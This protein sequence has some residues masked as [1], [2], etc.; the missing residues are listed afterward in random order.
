M[1]ESYKFRLYPNE[2]QKVLLAKHFG[3]VRFV[4]NWALDYNTKQ[5]V[6]GKKYTGWMT[7]VSGGEFVKLKEDNPWLYEIGANSLINVVGHLDKAYQKFF[8]HQGGFPKYKSK[9]DNNQS[10]EVPSGLKLFFKE[11]KIQI[12]KFLNKKG[13]DNRIK[14]VFCRK[15]KKG[16]IG[17]AT[18]S[19]NAAGQYFVSFIV[20]TEESGRPLVNK[21][22]LTTENSLGV[23]FGLKHFITLSDGRVIDSPEFFKRTLDKVAWEQHKLSKKQ[24]GSKNREKQRL[25]VAKA[26]QHIS[27][28]REDF[29]H[30]LTTGL[31]N[32]SQIQAICIEDL[33]LRKMS[34]R[35]GRKVHDL[36]Y[37][38]FTTMLD[39]KLKRRGKHLL[40]IGRFEPSSQICSH[41]GHR[42][43]ISLNERTYRCPICGMEMDRDVNASR[44]IKMF[45]LRDIL[46]NNTD[47]T[48]G[49][50]ACGVEGSG[51]SCQTTQLKPSTLKQ[52]NLLD[53]TSNP[54]HL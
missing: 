6:Q 51:L 23:D 33:D 37:Y 11:E 44:N 53:Y 43:K 46:K 39:Y 3:S 8:R 25:K 12:P 32:E 38:K 15:V 41:C 30:K 27:N 20:H 24:K 1:I 42:E 13:I 2:E 21:A 7:L 31:A 5:Y 14:C 9:Y 50:N 4:Y 48:S 17:T 45:A 10:F 40:K 19:R 29:L 18:I 35:W 36:S 16:K 47:A 34:K 26:Y 52:E 28:Q 49:I 22:T 54:S